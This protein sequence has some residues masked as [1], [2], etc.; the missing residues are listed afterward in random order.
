MNALSHNSR[1]LCLVATPDEILTRVSDDQGHKRPLLSVPNPKERIVELLQA[2]SDKYR[3]FPQIVTDEK[4]PADIA[5][6]LVEF[7]NTNPKSLTVENPQKSYE[8]VV[9][10]G[11]LPFIR[12]LTGAEGETVII[13]DEVVNALYGPSC[14]SIGHIIEIPSGRENKSRYCAI[15]VRSIN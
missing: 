2:R 11:L 14:A 5:R 9:G 7:I 13:T 10:A 1:V 3:R 4:K 6:G 15:C 12:Q 8:Y